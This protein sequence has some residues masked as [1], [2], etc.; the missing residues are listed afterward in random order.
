MSRS[1]TMAVPSLAA[2]TMIASNSS[3]FVSSPC[4]LTTNVCWVP[5]SAGWP[6]IWP[7]PNVW[8]WLWIAAETSCTVMP[9][10]AIRSG[11][12]HTRIAMSGSPSTDARFAPGTRFSSSS[13]YRFA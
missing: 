5:G 2:R 4:A 13:T 12:S 11:C 6:P 9:S 7:M 3:G 8:F 1:R 10:C